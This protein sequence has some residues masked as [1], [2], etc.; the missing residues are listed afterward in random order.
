MD[1]LWQNL[2]GNLAVVALFISIWTHIR[3]WIMRCS[4]LMRRIIF[5]LFMGGGAVSSML[6]AFELRPG[7]FFDLRTVLLGTS[8]LFGGPYA[9][10]V[11]GGAALAYRLWVGGGGVW[12]GCIGITLASLVGV[13]M[14][15]PL[16]NRPTRFWHVGLLS[17]LVMAVNLVGFA[18]LPAPLLS[19]IITNLAPL[20]AGLSFL[21][22]LLA[23][24]AIME[25]R[26][27]A[28]ERDLLL[29]ALA[30]APEFFYVKNA[31]SQFA[32]VNQSVANLHGFNQPAEMIGKTDY[33]LAPQG[34]AQDLFD[35]EQDL[36]SSGAPL[37]TFEEELH[38]GAGK[39][40]WYIT[41]KVP[42]RDGDGVLIGLAGVTRDVTEDKAIRAELEASRNLMSY[43]LT[44]MSDGLAMFDQRGYLVFA[45]ERYR[46]SFPLSGKV[47]QPGAHMRDILQVVVDNRE[48]LTVPHGDTAAWVEQRLAMLH[49]ESEEEVHLFNGQWLHLRTRPTGDGSSMVVVSDVSTLKQAEIKLLAATEQLQLLASTDGLT[50]LV[51]RRSFDQALER[52]VNR[53]ARGLTPLSLLLVDVDRFKAYNDLYGHPAGDECLRAVSNCLKAILRRPGDLAARYGG[54][55]FA[56]ILPETDEDGA[57]FIADEFQKALRQLR[58]R[59]DGSEKGT[60][61]VSIGIAT[62]GASVYRRLPSELIEKADEALYGA[63]AAGRDRINGWHARGDSAGTRPHL[64]QR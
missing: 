59:H 39:A 30:Q 28:H 7:F 46:A 26:R 63:K 42:L 21:A 15:L 24:I 20:V 5:G 52:E 34:R 53:S 1:D 37:L 32:A 47:R 62:Y 18:A 57:Y 6:M 17:V 2:I 9:A 44:E 14:Y 40:R 10:A 56:A 16:R 55:E 27:R 29:A 3:H 43:A 51:N 45:N 54:E 22:T 49:V 41:S 13:A 12:A 35:A 31:Q 38:D 58:I 25:S 33:D 4:Q 64:A 48:Q 36:L 8:G 11:S 61:S 23:G 50:G 19:Q 60:V